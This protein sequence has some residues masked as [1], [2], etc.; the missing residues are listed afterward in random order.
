MKRVIGV[1]LCVLMAFGLFANGSTEQSKKGNGSV[2]LEM[3]LSDDTLEG[4]AMATVVKKFNEEYKDKGIQVK[5]NEIAYADQETQIQNRASINQLPALIKTTH[6]EKYADYIHPLEDSGMKDSDFVVS[7]I[8][9]GKFLGTPVNTTAVGLIINKTAF[10][11]AGVKYPTKEEDRW[12]WD[13][14]LAALDKVVKNSDCDYGL[15]ID[16]SQ[17]RIG[18]ILYQYGMQEEDPKD[19]SKII[20]RSQDTKNGI[21]AILDIYKK[22]ISPVSIGTGTENAQSSFKT[23]KVAA[24]LCGNWV[25][26]DYTANIKSFEWIPVL[27]PYAKQKATCLGGNWLYAFEGSGQEKEAEE[28]IKWFYQPENYS[29][30]CQTGNYLPGKKGL[31]LKY[32]VKGLEI[33]NQELQ[34][35]WNQPELDKAV[36]NDHA[37]SSWGNA[38]RDAMDKA[39]AGEMNADQVMDYVV[40]EIKD[41]YPD[42]HE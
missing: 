35:T 8:L 1:V 30:Y 7:G 34:V 23:G 26:N 15:A 31:D 42:L 38:I 3:L 12:T 25:L 28:F 21:N 10:D 41:A 33:F 40:K 24:H 39:L 36:K 29:I 16:H 20:F 11:K 37:G 2:V 13:E 4:G 18:T 19:P 6:F 32:T 22:G 14:F 27:M 17:Q 5:I 9:K